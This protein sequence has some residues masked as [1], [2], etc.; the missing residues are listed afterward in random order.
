MCSFNCDGYL[1]GFA[2]QLQLYN[3]CLA[4]FA[5]PLGIESML[6]SADIQS[7]YKDD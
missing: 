2:H 3:A 7:E 6:S 5:E 4:L 1:N